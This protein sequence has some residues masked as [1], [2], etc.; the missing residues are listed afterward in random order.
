MPNTTPAAHRGGHDNIGA[1]EPREISL[2]E[3]DAARRSAGHPKPDLH[4]PAWPGEALR[5]TAAYQASLRARLAQESR[6][7]QHQSA[8]RRAPSRPA[9]RI[10]RDPEPAKLGSVVACIVGGILLLIGLS[11]AGQ[12]AA[13]VITSAASYRT[14]DAK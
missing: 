2:L 8:A 4:K 9:S 3:W 12:W 14:G 11:T 5:E 7:A 13:E 10:P 6:T 1:S